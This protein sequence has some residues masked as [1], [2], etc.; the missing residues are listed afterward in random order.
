[1]I[2]MGF[3]YNEGDYLDLVIQYDQKIF[4]IV[5]KDFLKNLVKYLVVL[6]LLI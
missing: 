3:D 2:A 5:R 4:R 1:M 6:R